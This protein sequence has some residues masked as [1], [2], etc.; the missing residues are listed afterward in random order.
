MSNAE[1]YTVHAEYDL[2]SVEIAPTYAAAISLARR[3]R[4]AA[5]IKSGDVMVAAFHPHHGV[6]V[7]DKTLAK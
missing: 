4:R 5:L 1:K 7:Y 6:V 2:D 3:T